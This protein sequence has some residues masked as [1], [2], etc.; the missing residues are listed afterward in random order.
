M[1]E[2]YVHVTGVVATDVTGKL[3]DDVPLASFRLVSTARRFDRTQ[4]TW[5]DGDKTWLTVTCWRSLAR[6]VI[7]SVLKT[8][9]VVVCGRLKVS[10]WRDA[11]GRLRSRT[12]VVADSIGHDL[13]FGTSVHTRTPRVENLILDPKDL[14]ASQLAEGHERQTDGLDEQTLRDLMD[15]VPRP[16]TSP[17]PL[18]PGEATPVDDD[19]EEREDFDDSFDDELDDA[20]FLGAESEALPV[21]R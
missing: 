11:E 15:G 4:R 10:E 19:E 7:A 9:R 21:P 1:N 5:V 8:E 14:A 2:I 17:D 6:N 12:E 20:T 16:L 13:T 3:V 18:V